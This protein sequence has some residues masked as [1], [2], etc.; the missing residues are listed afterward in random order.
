MRYN[1][2]ITAYR[3]GRATEVDR[4]AFQ[5]ELD[6]NP[7]LASEMAALSLTDELLGFAAQSV[8]QMPSSSPAG[9]VA[10]SGRSFSSAV[11]GGVLAA[12]LLIGVSAVLMLDRQ[13]VSAVE[14]QPE[15]SPRHQVPASQ[16]EPLRILNIPAFQQ[17]ENPIAVSA[18]K[19]GS[20]DG[21]VKPN[22]GSRNAANE[23]AQQL[24]QD[25][26]KTPSADSQTEVFVASTA[27]QESVS[28][29]DKSKLEIY[30]VE[31][32]MD[33]DLPKHADVSVVATRSITLKPGFSTG[34]GVSF[35][36]S[37]N[38]N[39]FTAASGVME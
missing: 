31:A 33:K 22:Q 37:I 5:H 30:T 35:K 23:S 17:I 18:P 13:P 20:D 12:L 26:Q 19:N 8:T 2:L 28:Q 24:A 39:P 21:A 11:L 38:G 15:F 10:P 29:V 34:Q 32:V 6:D 1:S 7:V 27:T 4:I 36:A 14:F 9:E 25:Q 3:D 16:L